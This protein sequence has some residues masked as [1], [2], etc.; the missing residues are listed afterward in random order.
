MLKNYLIVGKFEFF[1]EK[2]KKQKRFCIFVSSTL[3][4]SFIF[5]LFINLFQ[6][7]CFYLKL[8]LKNKIRFV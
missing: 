7:A 1:F 6:K 5:N 2:H 3:K 8:F 4:Y